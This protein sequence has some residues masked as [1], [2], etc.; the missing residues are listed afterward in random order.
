MTTNHNIIQHRREPGHQLFNS[1][2]NAAE[3]AKKIAR[4]FPR[5]N[6]GVDRLENERKVVDNVDTYSQEKHL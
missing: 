4:F 5:N 2:C 3:V 1:S 6:T